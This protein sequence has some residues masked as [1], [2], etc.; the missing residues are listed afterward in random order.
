MLNFIKVK[1]FDTQIH[2]E[3]TTCND[4]KIQTNIE[5]WE[6][7]SNVQEYQC[8]QN[9]ILNINKITP[10][11]EVKIL[12]IVFTQC[13]IFNLAN[14]CYSLSWNT[15]YIDIQVFLKIFYLMICSYTHNASIVSSLCNQHHYLE[16]MVWQ[17]EPSK[18]QS[19]IKLHV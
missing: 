7:K 5:C 6:N 12:K 17:M 2:V 10:S 9:E 3:S 14:T 4:I 1:S 15:F 11:I 16:H 19:L 8:L 13:I 18:L